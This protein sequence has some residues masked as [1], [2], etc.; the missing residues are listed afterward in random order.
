MKRKKLKNLYVAAVCLIAFILWTA[1][2]FFI[3]VRAVGPRGTSVGFATLNSA[4]HEFFGV[5]MTLYH[6]T[7]W[8]GLVPIFTALGFAVLGLVEWICRKKLTLVDINL[9]IL[10]G[11][12]IVVILVYILFESVTVNCRP[13]LID[14]FLETSYPSSTT[15]LTLCVMPTAL[16]QFR[17]RIKNGA[18][19]MWVSLLISAFTVFMV[20]GRLVSGVHWF[21]DIVGGAL[22]SA[23]L[24]FLYR[25]LERGFENG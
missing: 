10:G 19:K 17:G 15:L 2:L 6:V 8:L 23:S 18:L 24:V 21:S 12:Y 13:V 9:F 7:D 25:Y 4:I 14:G 3:D 1:A 11:F 16:M 5:N 22:I 20:V